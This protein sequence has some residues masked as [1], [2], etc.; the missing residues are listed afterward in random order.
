MKRSHLILALACG[1]LPRC[2]L[3]TDFCQTQSKFRKVGL[4]LLTTALIIH[5]DKK[6]EI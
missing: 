4:S 3:A 1:V 2:F 6:C 5:T